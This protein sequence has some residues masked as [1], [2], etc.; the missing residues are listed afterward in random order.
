MSKRFASDVAFSPAVMAVQERLGSRSGCAKMEQ[1]RGWQTRVTPELTEFLAGLD[2]FY[3]GTASADV[4]P[5]IQYRGDPPGF[6]KVLDD[7]TLGFADFSGNRQ[8]ITTGNLSENPRA[9]VFLMD[10]ANRRRIKIWGAARVVDNDAALLKRLQDSEYEAP[11]ERAVIF[12]VE[13]WDV[14]CPQHVHQRLP[15]REV[16][17]VVERL[18]QRVM[19][20]EEQLRNSKSSPRIANRVPTPS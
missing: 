9:F 6:L 15:A 1:V 5:Y 13:A 16:V 4:Q 11:V 18:R 20:L 17:A 8:Y 2:M 10:Y 3:F 19:E 7:H 14:N 12:E